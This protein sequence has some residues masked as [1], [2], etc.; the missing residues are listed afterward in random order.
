MR[1][2]R[3]KRDIGS[4]EFPPFLKG[5]E[6]GL[7]SS[8]MMGSMRAKT[9]TFI[10]ILFI[11]FS[12]SSNLAAQDHSILAT[13]VS[14]VLAKFPAENAKDKEAFAAE[15][16]SLG[17]DGLRDVLGRLAAPGA[18]DDSLARFAL[19]AVAVN[20]SRAGAESERLIFVKELLKALYEPRDA[21]VKAFLLSELQLVGKKEIVKPLRRFLNDPE[22]CGPAARALVA[23]HAPEAETVLLK[24][25]AAAPA[26]NRIELIQALGELRSA[27]ASK[28]ILTYAADPDAGIRRAAIFALAN[29][30]DPVAQPV[31]ERSAVTASPYD[32]AR[33]ASIYLLFAQ[34]QWENGKKD[35]A[36]RICRDFIRNSTLPEESQVRASALTL[37]ARILGAGVLDILLEAAESS[38]VQ[39]RQKAL[40]LAETVPGEKATAL[41]LEKLAELRPENQGDVIAMLG[42][43]GDKTALPGIRQRIGSEDKSVSLAAAVASARLGGDAVFDDVWPLVWSED[44]EQARAVRQALSFFSPARVVAKAPSIL[45]A[46]PA[47]TRIA[48]I[49]MLAERKAR[50]AAG[51]VLAQAR[52]EDE[53]V[54]KAAFAALES[55][56]R[57]DDALALIGLLSAVLG[58]PDVAPVQNALVAAANQIPEPERRAEAVLTAL[59]QAQGPK[60]ADLVKP[61]ARI[62][63]EKAL[64]FVISAARNPDPQLQAAALYAL[65]NWLDGSALEE[66]WKTA[67]TTD[68]NKSRY[69]A[70]QGIARLTGDLEYSSERK[71]LLLREALDIAVEVNEKNLILSA[72][73][74]IR[75]PESLKV[76]AK[77]LDD[78]TL[79][80]RAAQAV[81]RMVMPAPGAA[82][83]AGLETAMI[84]KK[85][86]L[87]IDN[88]YDRDEA[89]RYARSLL[90]K[91]GFTALFNGKDLAGWKGLVADPP[92]RSQVT[93]AELKK[94]QAEADAL[95][96]KHWKVVEGA[97][98]FNGQGHSLCTLRD[99]GD[100]EMFVDWKIQEKGDSG[101]YLRGSPQVQ[102]WDLTQSPDG[103]GGLYNNKIN[104]SK[105]LVRADR[106][107]GEWNTFHIKMTGERVT[108]HLNGI[109]VADN[110]VME[111]YWEREKP[112]Y[113]AGQIE[114]QAHSTPLTFKNIYIREFPSPK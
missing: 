68:D 49:E 62:G 5:D 34:R 72:L 41:W 77:F 2:A 9:I 78:K 58:T 93:P 13:K 97:L 21:E 69:L 88:E 90:F 35:A 4:C 85:A 40:E 51:L 27:A 71:L 3:T 73:A 99:F 114:L 57:P 98:V 94:A 12:I 22:L 28:K 89:E 30:G 83:L 113:P 63:G 101:I 31:L 55:L 104:P 50:E 111:N 75:T 92:K 59:E 60:R 26:K 45:M 54:R 43:R 32:R 23:S 38:D 48:L 53:N 74:G 24:S 15:L 52:S 56:A 1:K 61:L 79:Q 39:F 42:R 25:L 17:P 108:V 112:I 110:V 19:D 81:L 80:V 14:T 82:G 20:V 67:R 70:L 96:R 10:L 107:V 87:S 65:S 95:M 37:L 44:G 84:L 103:S 106:P 46:A 91:N 100:F 66:L 76:V 102:I 29:I 105:P 11:T 8:K 64:S 7:S 36:E 18:D 33:S 47:Q 86:L 16:V 109:I 6:G